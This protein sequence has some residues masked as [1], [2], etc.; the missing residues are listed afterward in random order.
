MKAQDRP[1]TVQEILDCH[2]QFGPLNWH[3]VKKAMG[4]N[5]PEEWEKLGPGE[6]IFHPEEIDNR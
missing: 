1:P 3:M 6:G 5:W 4:P 2:A